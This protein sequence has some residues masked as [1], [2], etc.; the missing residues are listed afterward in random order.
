MS[1]GQTQK[2]SDEREKQQIKES[3]VVLTKM[4]QPLNKVA[5]TGA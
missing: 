2:S 4:D 1:S 3:I 5:E